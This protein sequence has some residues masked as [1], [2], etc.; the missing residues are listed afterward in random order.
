MPLWLRLLLRFDGGIRTEVQ[1]RLAQA[2]WVDGFRHLHPGAP[3]YTLPA[4]SPRVRLDY[5]LV[6]SPLLDR[7]AACEPAVDAPLAARA[8]D[9][10]PLVAEFTVGAAGTLAPS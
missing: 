3:G 10:L 8:S 7:L 2:G 5:V 1:D 9:H 6:P 4:M